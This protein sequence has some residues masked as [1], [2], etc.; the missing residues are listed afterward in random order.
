MEV[1]TQGT[2]MVHGNTMNWFRDVIHINYRL[3]SF[4]SNCKSRKIGFSPSR[5]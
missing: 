3:F 2:H 4:I 5:V 1:V